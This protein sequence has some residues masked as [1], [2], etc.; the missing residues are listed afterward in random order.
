MKKIISV[1]F[2]VPLIASLCPGFAGQA[3]ADDTQGMHALEEVQA[4][5]IRLPNYVDEDN[6]YGIYTE[7]IGETFYDG[8]VNDEDDAI[9][10]I[11]SVADRIRLDEDTELVADSIY[12]NEEGVT[13]YSFRQALGSLDIY[14]S[15]V[16]LVVGKDKKVTGLT[17][18]LTFGYGISDEDRWEIGEEEAEKVVEDHFKDKG[19]K[20][21]KGATGQTLLTYDA[22]SNYYY[23]W[24]VYSTNDDPKSEA[25]Y[26][27]H[28]VR[29]TGE[30]LDDIPV[31]GI[32]DVDGRQGDVAPFVFTDMEPAT[33]TGT[34]RYI[35]DEELEIS[36]PV[37]E[38]TQ[39]GKTILGDAERKILC[40]DMA[41]YEYN[42]TIT[43][44]YDEDGFDN[45]YLGI[46][47]N[48][49]RTYE[50]YEKAG[51]N[52]PD[53]RGTPCILLMNYVDEEG[54]PVD[55][56]YYASKNRGF[57]KFVFS[58]GFGDY[59]CLDTVAHEFTHCISDAAL[60]Y[61]FYQNDQGAINEAFSDIMANLIEMMYEDSPGGEWLFNENLPG[62]PLRSMKE[63]RLYRNPDYV[64]D[65]YYKAGSADPNGVNDRG[66]VHNNSS[67]LNRVSYLL[68]EGGMGIEEQFYYWM[69]V[70][71]AMTPTTDYPQLASIMKWCLV[72]IGYDQYSEALDK[73]IGDTGIT[74]DDV[75]IELLDDQALIFLDASELKDQE[76]Y[77]GCDAYIT[78]LGLSDG[79]EITNWELMG[80]GL[81]YL[82]IPE[83]DY[84]ISVSFKDDTGTLVYY[85]L[86]DDEWVNIDYSSEED[87]PDIQFVSLGGGKYYEVNPDALP[88]A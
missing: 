49:I 71:L 63:P 24:V 29:G 8:D 18:T 27:A 10:A 40:A 61:V 23:V 15:S 39:T 3:A 83:G 6:D 74:S 69:N 38:D 86:I 41:D 55:N 13:Y 30:Y 20:V 75:K 21:I 52:G 31:S 67:L 17:S 12:H 26:L 78:V 25:P 58:K 76:E 79:V 56:C 57:Q 44:I 87:V 53:G 88:A 1:L 54:N 64:W 73:A 70:S 45:E 32:G 28:F 19:I 48:F 37:M 11:E 34:I 47:Y 33:W 80:S 68:Y 5:D 16:K 22:Q 60:G 72:N 50:F 35:N 85:D 14:S 81:V 36:V 46:Y 43:P 77:Q 62:G 4:E 66:G 84:S 65:E 59:M 82:I 7:F 42:N 51:W 2:I 9:E